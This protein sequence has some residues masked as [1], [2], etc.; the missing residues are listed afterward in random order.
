MLKKTLFVFYLKKSLFLDCE[1]KKNAIK[2]ILIFVVVD[3]FKGEVL[4][5]Y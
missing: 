1:S 2:E 4:A 5:N 3:F